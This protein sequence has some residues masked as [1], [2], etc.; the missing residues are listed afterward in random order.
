MASTLGASGMTWSIG[1]AKLSH[2]AVL[3]VS[4]MEALE[5]VLSSVDGSIAAKM[6]NILVPFQKSK[7]SVV[8]G[9]SKWGRHRFCCRLGPARH[10]DSV[11]FFGRW[12]S[13]RPVTLNAA[14]PST[15]QEMNHRPR[16]ATQQP[17]PASA[18]R[19][20]HD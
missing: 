11:S 13:K 12:S 14:A 4:S 3:D 10:A 18:A 17:G 1:L 20:A 5:A 8:C 6:F 19:A 16:D 9:R 7:K 2:T 15:A